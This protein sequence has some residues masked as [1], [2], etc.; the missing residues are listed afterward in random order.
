LAIVEA[1]LGEH[2]VKQSAMILRHDD[3]IS[4]PPA[5]T[6]PWLNDQFTHSRLTAGLHE[7]QLPLESSSVIMPVIDD[8]FRHFNTIVPLFDQPTFMHLLQEWFS[9][10][11]TRTT[12]RWAA[13]HA[14][15]GI[16]MRNFGFKVASN[17]SKVLRCMRNIE[18]VL[19][20]VVTSTSDLTGLQT[21]LC[22]VM[23]YQGTTDP[24]P[25]TALVATAVRL[26]HRLRLHRQDNDRVI[27]PPQGVQGNRVLWILYILDRDIS[28]R[29]HDPYLL[30]DHD[31]DVDLPPLEPDDGA[32]VLCTA[33]GNSYFNFLLCRIQLA[34]IQS[35]MYDW[36]YSVRAEKSGEME[37]Q[38]RVEQLNSMLSAWQD[39]IPAS[40]RTEMDDSLPVGVKQQLV[41]MHF[42]HHYSLL[43]INQVHVNSLENQ[44]VRNFTEWTLRYAQDQADDGPHVVELPPLP[45]KW[46][47][48]VDQARDCMALV[49]HVNP[50]DYGHIWSVETS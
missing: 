39:S 10:P 9:T 28:M 22:L 41:V 42:A 27:A 43:K 29:A 47:L 35:K 46:Q 48:C 21:V 40:F 3:A 25:A 31:M 33:T 20:D 49:R 26:A 8:F 12:V 7:V 1:K 50:V 6:S 13:I 36:L 24:R 23:L 37:R 45:P 34:R 4:P 17:E 30:Q 16:S 14:V 32:G 15:L 2:M 38:A 11:H 5:T 18:A 19:D 44:R